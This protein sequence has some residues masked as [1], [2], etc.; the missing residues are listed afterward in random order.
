MLHDMWQ[1]GDAA[2]TDE[3]NGP[4]GVE[5]ADSVDAAITAATDLAAYLALHSPPTR[6]PSRSPARSI[7]SPTDDSSTD[8][9]VEAR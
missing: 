6:G 1:L 3:H 8:F 9:P 4:A 5:A 7:S 2:G